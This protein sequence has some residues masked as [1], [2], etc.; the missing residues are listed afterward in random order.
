[1]K[2]RPT[3]LWR[4]RIWP[5]PGSP[6]GTSTIFMVSGPPFWSIWT[7]LFMEGLLVVAAEKR[8]PSCHEWSRAARMGRVP[9]P[10][11]LR[12]AT[13]P[14][15]CHRRPAHHS[16]AAVGRQC[17]GRPAHGGPGPAHD[18]ELPAL[19]HRVRAA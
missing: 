10:L 3:A 11:Q 4:M 8:A 15:A 17:G 13:T 1:M 5:G 7:V 12:H 6:T 18:A 14:H 9:T 2:F 16:A 19:G